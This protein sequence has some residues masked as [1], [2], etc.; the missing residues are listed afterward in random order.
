V[1]LSV[2]KLVKDTL[3]RFDIAI[4]S[5]SSVEGLVEKGRSH[6][7][8][9]LL[10]KFNDEQI[11]YFVKNLVGKSRAQLGQDLFV[12]SELN[13]KRNGFFVEFGATNGVDLSNTALLEREFG[14]N[15]ILAIQRP[16]QKLS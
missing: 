5:Q 2:R 8:L 6:H 13:L 10:S 16:S 14:W 1:G 3:R 12:L 9:A 15:G 7:L 11:S 4:T